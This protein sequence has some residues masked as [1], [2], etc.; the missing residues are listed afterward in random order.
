MI[1][2]DDL[3]RFWAKAASDLQRHPDDVAALAASRHLFAL[4]TLVTPWTGPI[5]TASVVLLAL[6]PGLTETGVAERREAQMP[7]GRAVMAQNLGGDAPLPS[8]ATSRGWTERRLKQFGL[9]Y[10]AAAIK[11]VFVNLM[12]Y[13]SREGAKDHHMLGR[14]TSVRMVRAWAR[15]TLFREARAGQRVV[16][17]LRSARDWGLEP[18]TQEGAALFAPR[19]TRSGYIFHAD[20]EKVGGA[21]RR[22]AFAAGKDEAA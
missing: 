3:L 10:A 1:T 8:F 21:V 16:I 22:A 14:L 2:T 7:E 11:V 15:D 4:D 9:S 19:F 12:P 5:R 18:N 17:C 6:N 13:R 20:R